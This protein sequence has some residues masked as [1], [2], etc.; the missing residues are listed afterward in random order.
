M[1]AYDLSLVNLFGSLS[2]TS[3]QKQELNMARS[4]TF[5]FIFIRVSTDMRC[6]PFHGKTDCNFRLANAMTQSH[7]P[8]LQ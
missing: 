4:T 8:T 7:S 5:S 3:Q 2:A 1:I 6:L